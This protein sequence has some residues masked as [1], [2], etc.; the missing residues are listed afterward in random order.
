MY[1]SEML[2]LHWSFVVLFCFR[3]IFR[4]KEGFIPSN[5]MID[6]FHLFIHCTS[7][8]E[9]LLCAEDELLKLHGVLGADIQWRFKAMLSHNC[10][11]YVENVLINIRTATNKSA[12]VNPSLLDNLGGCRNAIIMQHSDTALARTGDRI[13]PAARLFQW[14]CGRIGDASHWSCEWIMLPNIII[15]PRRCTSTAAT[16]R[17]PRESFDTLTLLQTPS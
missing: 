17:L 5:S 8:G 14:F 4:Y 1:D 11:K 2:I 12:N 9:G 10:N 15:I 3:F 13:D 6:S 16:N 7:C